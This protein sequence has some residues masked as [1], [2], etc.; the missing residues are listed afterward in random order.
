MICNLS[1]GFAIAELLYI[2]VVWSKVI[3]VDVRF[4]VL[5][6]EY[7]EVSHDLFLHGNLLS[8]LPYLFVEKI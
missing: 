3:F 4:F 6:S 5:A 1:S 8:V 2:N 7:S